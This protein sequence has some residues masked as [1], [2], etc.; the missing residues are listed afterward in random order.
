MYSVI[1]ALF[2][3]TLQQVF[4]PSFHLQPFPLLCLP[5]HGFAV[6]LS[7][8]PG[9]A[10]TQLGKDVPSAQ[11]QQMLYEM[12]YRANLPYIQR[13]KRKPLVFLAFSL[14]NSISSGSMYSEAVQI[15]LSGDYTSPS[16]VTV[17]RILSV[18]QQFYLIMFL[19]HIIADN[20]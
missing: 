18:L 6:F 10:T 20:K 12:K 14:D 3:S 16:P 1:S 17:S 11:L 2:P 15:P 9:N 8:L 19:S 5:F 13:F 4:S 7:C